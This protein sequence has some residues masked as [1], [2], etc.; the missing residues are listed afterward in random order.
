MSRWN[1]EPI[2]L[3]AIVVA[4]LGMYFLYPWDE[5]EP[6]PV[7]SAIVV[8]AYTS[9]DDQC[10]PSGSDFRAGTPVTVSAE[11]GPQWTTQLLA[12]IEVEDTCAMPFILPTIDQAG[13]YTVSVPSRE[14]GVRSGFELNKGSTFMLG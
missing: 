4:C 9:R 6:D 8:T 13:S 2:A 11:D 10:L 14:L 12:G 1:H 3:G 7:N 5:V